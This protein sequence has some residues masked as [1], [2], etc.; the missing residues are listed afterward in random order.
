MTSDG[1][2][3]IRSHCKGHCRTS[4]PLTLSH[5]SQRGQI[6][7]DLHKAMAGTWGDFHEDIT[8]IWGLPEDKRAH[9]NPALTPGRLL[10]VLR[11]S[12]SL[13][14]ALQVTNHHHHVQMWTLRVSQSPSLTV[15]GGAG[16][17]PKGSSGCPAHTLHFLCRSLWN[18]S[19]TQRPQPPPHLTPWGHLAQHSRKR[20]LWRSP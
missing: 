20:G 17:E 12:H 1:A 4:W 5:V 15:D 16:L 14:A 8:V 7:G 11:S 6:L 18:R 3:Y 10:Q 13:A 19:P 2:V 9:R